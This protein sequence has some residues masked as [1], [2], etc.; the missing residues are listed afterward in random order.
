MDLATQLELLLDVAEFGTFAKAADRNHI[1]RSALSKQIKRLEDD[2]GLR[3]LNRSTRSLSLTSAGTEMV[4]QA[5]KVREVLNETKKIAETFHDEPRGHLKISSSTFFGRTYINRA[6]ELFIKKYPEISVEL[7]LD[8]NRVD[9]ISEGYDVVFRIGQIRDSNMI[10]RKLASNK[11]ALVASRDFIETYG[12][13]ETPE[14]LIKLPSIVY[15]NESFIADKLRI[16]TSLDS[17]E[18]KT[19]T[20]R[21]QYLVNEAESIIDSVKSGLGYAL[22]GQFYL[23]K[24]IDEQ[25]LIRLLPDYKLPDSGEVY[26]TAFAVLSLIVANGASAAEVFSNDTTT[27][28]VHGRMQGM[29]YFSDDKDVD[30]DNSYVRVGL[31]GE[32]KIN[33]DLYA[34]GLYELEFKSNRRDVNGVEDDEFDV[35]KGYV[36]VATDYATFSYGRQYGAVTLV[37]DYTDIFPE[38]GNEAAGV[39]AD[40]FGTGRSDSVFKA[41]ASIAGLNVHAS[42]QAENDEV[43]TD[44]NSYGIAADYQLP[45][46]FKVALGYNEGETLTG[47]RSLTSTMHST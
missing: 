11:L 18:T 26:E 12:M 45:F 35:R 24:H 47:L 32:S 43:S 39:S 17:D 22:I 30:G 31:S 8:D 41:T 1:D 38:F 4:K 23:Q 3:L 9:V 16:P 14:E 25:G 15:S 46:G 42:Y 36:G 34:F 13:P 44:S 2:L 27:L 40:V 19:F 33:D 20:M 29:Y 37:S 7:V 6:I 28:D 21:G 5:K 10:V